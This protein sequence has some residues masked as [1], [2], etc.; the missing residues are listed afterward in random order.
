MFGD[1][2]GEDYFGGG[3]NGL[4]VVQDLDRETTTLEEQDDSEIKILQASELEDELQRVLDR[5]DLNVE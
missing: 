2:D 5:T 1:E 4:L 3:W